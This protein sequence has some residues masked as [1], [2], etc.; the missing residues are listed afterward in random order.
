[1]SPVSPVM[2]RPGTSDL[3]VFRAVYYEG[4]YALGSELEDSFEP[5][6]VLDAGAYTGI[7][8][9][10]FCDRWP[11]ATVVAVEPARE[12]LDLARVNAPRADLRPFAVGGSSRVAEIRDSEHGPAFWHLREDGAGTRVGPAQVVTVENLLGG[13][14]PDV[15]KIDIEGMEEELFRAPCGWLRDTRLLFVQTH[16]GL[17]EGATE[18]LQDAIERSG[19]AV[20]SWRLWHGADGQGEVPERHAIVFEKPDNGGGD[21]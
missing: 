8:S 1:M 5:D 20:R 9:R 19:K 21:G 2:V 6:L 12:S 14:S 16:D 3:V 7:S 15:A 10:Y 17:V 18:A 13:A 11:G 4:V